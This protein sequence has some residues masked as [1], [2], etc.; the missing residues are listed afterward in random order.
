MAKSKKPKDQEQPASE[1]QRKRQWLKKIANILRK[2]KKS[3]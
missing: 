3:R 1:E 2:K